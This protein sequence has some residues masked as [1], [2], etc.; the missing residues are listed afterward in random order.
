MLEQS[1]NSLVIWSLKQLKIR[2][3]PFCCRSVLKWKLRFCAQNLHSFVINR[4]QTSLAASQWT[5]KESF[6]FSKKVCK[7][8]VRYISKDFN[9]L[10]LCFSQWFLK[11]Q[12]HRSITFH[13]TAQLFGRTIQLWSQFASFQLFKIL[14][15]KQQLSTLSFLL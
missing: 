5:S 13:Y 3:I 11:F 12:D 4:F 8:A 2:K 14:P 10:R 15:S 7:Q 1:L 6:H 9:A